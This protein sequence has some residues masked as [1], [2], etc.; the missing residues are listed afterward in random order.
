MD[1][2]LRIGT[3]L[4]SKSFDA[5]IN[6]LERKLKLMTKTL[7][8]ESDIPVNL[9]MSSDERAKL[10][11]DIE[12][13]KNKIISLKSSMNELP[14]DKGKK[15]GDN[16]EKGLK[17]LNRFAWSLVSLRGAYSMLSRASSSYLSKDT[18]LAEKLQSVWVGLGSFL[19]PVLET[20]SNI[21][22]KALGYLNVFVRALTGIDFIANANAKA[23]SKQAQAQ[24]ELNKQT[25]QY[26][27]DE[28]NVQQ[29]TSI[30]S[31]GS[32]SDANSNLIQIPELDESIVGFLEDMA[33]WLKENWN[34]LSKVAEGLALAF[35]VAKISGW[36][37]NIGK[38]IGV[39]A[40]AS[41]GT[42]LLGLL[43]V[44]T[45]IAALT[46]IAICVSLIVEGREKLMNDLE[47]SKKSMESGNEA[48]REA[49]KEIAE[50]GK[51]QDATTE[52]INKSNDA[53][54]ALTETNIQSIENERQRREAALESMQTL[55][56]LGSAIAGVDKTLQTAN[57]T[58]KDNID[59]TYDTIQEWLGLYKQGK[60]NDE[61]T[62][63]L[64][65][66]MQA[67]ISTASYSGTSVEQLSKYFGINEEEAKKLQQK[68]FDINDT[69][70]D[71]NTDSST[72]KD[73]IIDVKDAMEK[74]PK[75]VQMSIGADATNVKTTLNNLFSNANSMF[76]SALSA[77]SGKKTSVNL[78]KFAKGGIVT[79]P[80]RALIGEAGYPEAVVP[81]QAEYLST[82]ADLI[83]QYSG[84][85]GSGVVNVYL[86][87]RLIQRQIASRTEE[88]DFA[89]NG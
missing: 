67:F 79:Q 55:G 16:F 61:Q 35:G 47:E 73:G 37:A 6:E 3:E 20:I 46:T 22:L 69:L 23:L 74:L 83:A 26:S 14:E 38:L 85:N 48:V 63:Q 76:S 36:I 5:Q 15:I 71:F 65:D 72:V 82:L 88:L 2:K 39:G 64:K 29:N 41:G 80:T 75:N 62:Q 53:L 1:G 58:M 13:V 52:T 54:K 78:F 17:S 11:S 50:Y 25:Q 12:K 7:E 44:L 28:M 9:R 86:D 40:G 68:Y 43:G 34:W 45:A 84:N 31:T 59:T 19:A 42:G 32:S 10:E 21:L 49:S 56:P 60:L 30:S 81:M 77:L 87:S 27:F 4:D 33:Y 24:K 8:S 57:D 51:Q 70:N 89:T 66:S 18:Q